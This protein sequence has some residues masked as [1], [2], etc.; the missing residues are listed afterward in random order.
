MKLARKLARKLTRKLTRKLAERAMRITMRLYPSI[1]AAGE[2]LRVL[3]Q[4]YHRRGLE[5]DIN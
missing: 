1:A 3:V 5:C 2:L 4:W